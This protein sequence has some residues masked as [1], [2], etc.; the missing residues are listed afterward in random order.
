MSQRRCVLW[1]RRRGFANIDV[2]TDV[3][4]CRQLLSLAPQQQRQGHQS[5]CSHV[6]R[7]FSRHFIFRRSSRSKREAKRKVGS[8]CHGTIDEEEYR[9]QLRKVGN[10]LV[11]LMF[12]IFHFR[13]KLA[14]FI[15]C[16]KSRRIIVGRGR[17]FKRRSAISK[18]SFGLLW[19][20]YGSDLS[21]T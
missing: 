15:I 17:N 18:P 9:S 10:P 19:K 13:A 4:R 8:G 14:T 16:S 6:W 7:G 3:S 5:G 11:L 20:T 2:M 12:C 1:N 21:L